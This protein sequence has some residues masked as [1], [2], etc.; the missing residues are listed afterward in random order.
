MTLLHAYTLHTWY[1]S[2]WVDNFPW[3]ARFNANLCV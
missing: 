2:T 1:Y 3:K